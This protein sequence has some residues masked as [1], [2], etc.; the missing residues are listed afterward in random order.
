MK[1]VNQIEA[2]D[3]LKSGKIVIFPTETSYGL[4]CDATNQTAVDKIF[5]IKGRRSD[6]PLLVVVSSVEMAKEYLEWN[7]KIE[8]L[9][10]K[11]WPGALTIVGK[12]KD[13]NL[14][15]GVVSKDSTVAIRVTNAEIPKYLSEQIGNPVVATSANLADQGDSY[16]SEEL[17]KVYKN[18]EFFPDAIIAVGVIE[19]KLPSTI[20]SVI[21]NKVKILRQGEVKIFNY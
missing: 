17:I 1:L 3:Y 2:L 14:A 21:D 8:N 13:N 7:D 4:G 9:A 10:T 11:Y 20:V 19:K 18:Q 16:D 5:K 15:N 12:I 6:K